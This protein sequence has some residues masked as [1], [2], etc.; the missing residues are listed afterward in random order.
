M[1]LRLE[2]LEVERVET[3]CLVVTRDI[4]FACNCLK[5]QHNNED[6]SIDSVFHTQTIVLSSKNN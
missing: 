4:G 3:G 6:Q 1:Y 5:P 2:E